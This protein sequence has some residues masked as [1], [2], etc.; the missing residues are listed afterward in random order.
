MK[1]KMKEAAAESWRKAQEV[2]AKAAEATSVALEKSAVDLRAKAF[3]FLKLSDEMVKAIMEM[4]W[5]LLTIALIL[6]ALR[7]L[8]ADFMVVVVLV[9]LLFGSGLVNLVLNGMIACLKLAAVAP[10]IFLCLLLVVLVAASRTGR[11]A[12]KSCGIDEQFLQ[13][14]PGYQTAMAAVATCY[15]S[16]KQCAAMEATFVKLVDDI[17]ANLASGD[18]M[19]DA[20]LAK[21][22]DAIES[23][24][25]A[26]LAPHS[27]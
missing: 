19:L 7:Y 24:L 6:I 8:S 20:E 27:A 4:S 21:R 23:K 22:L 16:F 11:A 17:E 12:F 14:L 15:G 3:E 26:A 2:S 5:N 10:D 18:S 9:T 25:D 1:D 13:Q